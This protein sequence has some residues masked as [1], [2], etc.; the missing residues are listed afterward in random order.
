MMAGGQ[1]PIEAGDLPLFSPLVGCPKAAPTAKGRCIDFYSGAN[2]PTTQFV[3]DFK[4]QAPAG[5]LP[6]PKALVGSRRAKAAS[7]DEVSFTA[8]DGRVWAFR[9]KRARVLLKFVEGAR[10]VTQWDTLP[11]HTRLAATVEALRKEGLEISTQIEGEYRHARYRL[12][13][14]GTLRTG[15]GRVM[16]FAPQGGEA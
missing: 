2:L 12:H 5:A 9:G 13:T 3:D 10:G 16:T 4:P 6:A 7:G 1:S 11:W 8:V 14:A 15:D